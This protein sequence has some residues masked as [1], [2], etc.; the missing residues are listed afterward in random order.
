MARWKQIYDKPGLR[1]HLAV[2]LIALIVC[3][4]THGSGVGILALPMLWSMS[5]SK[6]D[7]MLVFLT[8]FVGFPMSNHTLVPKG[9]VF[10]VTVKALWVFLAAYLAGKV[11][12]RRQS[13]L[14]TPF[15]GIIVYAGYMVLPSAA[16]WN[17]P[18]SFLKLFL[19][20]TTFFAFYEIANVVILGPRAT[21]IRIRSAFIAFALY[22][23]VGSALL[24][25]FPGISQM[26]FEQIQETLNAGVAVTSLYCG[27]MFHSQALGA[28]TAIMGVAVLADY[29]FSIRK[30][31]WLY[32]ILLLCAPILIYK[33]SS[34]TAM[35][36]L[37]A[38]VIF[39]FY[40]FM[41]TRVVGGAWKRKVLTVG[42]VAGMLA[43]IVIV[44]LPTGRVSVARFVTKGHHAESLKGYTT[45]DLMLSR[46]ELIDRAIFNFKKSP[47]LGNGFQVSEDYEGM[48]IKSIKQLL[49]A[50]IEK[51]VWV[52]A[53]LEEGGAIGMLLFLGFFVTCI[54]TLVRRKAY[55]GA[56]VFFTY[57]VS[58]LGE[59][60]MFAMSGVGG[61]AWAMCFMGVIMDAQRLRE[62][63]ISYWYAVDPTQA[64]LRE[65]QRIESMDMA[66]SGLD[67]WEQ[68]HR[69]SRG[70]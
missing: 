1:L 2:W 57:I 20:V 38:G 36:T 4:V 24:I 53:I 66:L 37:F 15:L 45:E 28:V 9:T 39:V 32:T 27:M 25:P 58:N 70:R 52:T 17:V 56:A 54:I 59:F 61:Y 26:R 19:F 13:P 67:V 5:G 14:T 10:N 33:T 69:S 40:L 60:S 51:G 8:I 48:K 7:L 21:V 34:R 22:I 6:Q 31:N 30:F 68:E 50:P 35:G 47:L 46:Q 65:M 49:S 62:E 12:G 64:D 16:G 63:N 41:R 43:M 44:A 23:L 42:C 18:I 55:T 29:L 11:A 3:Y